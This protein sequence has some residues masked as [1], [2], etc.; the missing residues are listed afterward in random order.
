MSAFIQIR[1]VVMFVVYRTLHLWNLATRSLREAVPP[2]AEHKAVRYAF[3]V[4][5]VAVVASAVLTYFTIQADE[6]DDQDRVTDLILW[7]LIPAAVRTGAAMVTSTLDRIH[8]KDAQIETLALQD[9]I[10]AASPLSS[11]PPATFTWPRRMARAVAKSVSRTHRA[12]HVNG[13]GE[14]EVRADTYAFQISTPKLRRYVVLAKGIEI[15]LNY[16]VQK[17][18]LAII[19][20]LYLY[21]QLLDD[22][23]RTDLNTWS[24]YV[25]IATTL[26]LAPLNH[27]LGIL[28]VQAYQQ[29]SQGY[30][31][32]I[33]KNDAAH[34]AMATSL[35][36]GRGN[37]PISRA[38]V[39]KMDP[40][41]RRVLA[42]IAA[43]VHVVAIERARIHAALDALHTESYQ[44]V[45]QYRNDR[46][47]DLLLR[48]L[49]RVHHRS[50]LKLQ[51][52]DAL[53]KARAH[54]SHY[55]TLS[56]LFAASDSWSATPNLDSDSDSDSD[57]A[58]SFLHPLPPGKTISPGM[59]AALLPTDWSSWSPDSGWS[60]HHASSA[61]TATTASTATSF[62][63]ASFASTASTASTATTA[64]T[65]T[66][67]VTSDSS[68]E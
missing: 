8:A 47:T 7:G 52:L 48:D 29:V 35:A 6:A 30:L 10:L 14:E 26:F 3:Y 12:S 16:V 21:P 43:S 36:P 55:A 17:A 32:V 51:A 5:Y 22:E 19:A 67:T 9:V 53:E 13:A 20:L 11:S 37:K 41:A 63:S 1:A 25:R 40:D 44:I 46:E 4:R 39:K 33:A 31:R 57:S 28:R 68:N 64:T 34:A 54:S 49:W 66:A 62:S 60:D 65:G 27:Y 59:R 2:S 38:A 24:R 56:T 45:T 23:T 58:I 61:S 50:K 15:P 42:T 18:F